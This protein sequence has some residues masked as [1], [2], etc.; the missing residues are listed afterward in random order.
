MGLLDKGSKRKLHGTMPEKIL[1]YSSVLLAIYLIYSSVIAYPYAIM[2]RGIFVTILVAMVML[3][4]TFPGEKPNKVRKLDYVLATL[5]LIVGVYI[6]VNT[7][8]LVFRTPFLDPILPLDFILGG[9]LILLVLEAT[10]RSVG[11]P[12]AII[13]TLMLAY[14]FLGRYIPGLFGHR[15]F[16]LARVVEQMFLTTNG[17][18]GE[19]IGIASSYVFMFVLFGA[20]LN[21]TGGGDFFFD[22]SRAIAGSARGGLAKTAVVASALFGSISGS[23]ISNVA[24]TGAMTIPMMKRSGYPNYFAAA[25]ETASSCGGTIMPPVMGAVAFLMAEVVGVTY[26]EVLIAAVIPALLYYAAVYYAVDAE[27]IR[28]GLKGD[29]KEDLPSPIKVVF[30]GLQYLVPLVWLVARLFIGFSPSRVAIEAVGLMIV[31]ALVLRNPKYPITL[32]QIMDGLE[33]SIKSLLTVATACAAAGLVIGVITLTGIGGKFTSLILA[34]GHGFLF[35][36]LLLT[37]IV[38]IILGMGMSITPTYLLAASLSAPALVK[39]GVTPMAAHLFIVYYAAMA[40]MTPPVSLAAYTAAGIAEADPLKV[41]FT[42]VKIGIVAFIIPYVFVYQPQL[43]LQSTNHLDTIFTIIFTSFGV[44]ALTA[45]INKWLFR[46]NKTWESILMLVACIMM[47][48]PIYLINGVGLV[49]FILTA[50]QQY[51]GVKKVL[52]KQN[53]A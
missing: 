2:Y 14:P 8:R 48:L 3:I 11:W 51:L 37:M 23:P 9:L 40:T 45:S 34:L 38:T 35:P 16:T 10:R 31:I 46:H 4:F 20:F 7:Q 53:V 49:I 32:Q 17:I 29:N 26:V 18:F 47:F 39:A 6:V 24:T 41:G 1:N 12:L 25:V 27:A 13:A 19:A 28:Q 5:S 43:I 52:T 30:G 33:S 42:A 50:I 36:A 15:G 21:S 44:V 22:L